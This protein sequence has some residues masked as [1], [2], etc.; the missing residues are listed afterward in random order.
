MKATYGIWL[1]IFI[2]SFLTAGFVPAVIIGVLA[3]GSS[4]TTGFSVAEKLD[5]SG[6]KR[7][8]Y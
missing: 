6:K 8:L 5:P 3:I 4:V 2:L 1:T 7:E